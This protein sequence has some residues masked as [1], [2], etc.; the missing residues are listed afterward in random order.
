MGVIATPLV[1]PI[2]P[3]AGVSN[4]LFFALPIITP[5]DVIPSTDPNLLANSL[6]LLLAFSTLSPV[7]VLLILPLPPLVSSSDNG[8][9]LLPL[10]LKLLQLIPPPNV[11]DLLSGLTSAGDNNND[12]DA[13]APLP[14]AEVLVRTVVEDAL[15]IIIPKGLLGIPPSPS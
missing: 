2:P 12:D 10:A 6:I 5:L 13:S 3:L 9:C 4:L 14:L 8:R 15:A 1:S 7:V 11:L